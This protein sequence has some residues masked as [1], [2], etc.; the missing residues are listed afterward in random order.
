VRGESADEFAFSRAEPLFTFGTSVQNG[1]DRG[2]DVTSDGERFLFFVEDGP[3]VSDTSVSLVL[4][5]NWVSELA[6]LVPREP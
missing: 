3:P 5:K 4:V 6:R 2:F 1:L